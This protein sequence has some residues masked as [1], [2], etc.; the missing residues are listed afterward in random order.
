MIHT[1]AKRTS[2][3]PSACLRKYGLPSLRCPFTE[4]VVVIHNNAVGNTKREVAKTRAR[5]VEEKEH[6]GYWFAM[7]RGLR[8][9]TGDLVITCEGDGTFLPS[10]L[11]KF[12]AYT[13]EFEVI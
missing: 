10:D 9:A 8:E 13:D 7:M 3:A 4:E 5:L 1:P 6:Q 2:G 11:L 12:V